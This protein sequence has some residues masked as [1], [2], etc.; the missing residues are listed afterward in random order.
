MPLSSKDPYNDLMKERLPLEN[1]L[2]SFVE[3][4]GDEIDG[5]QIVARLIEPS[6]GAS[7]TIVMLDKFA[8]EMPSACSV[9]ELVSTLSEHGFKG[10]DDYF[11]EQNSSLPHVLTTR[12]GIP[13]TL[14]IV[15]L[16]VARRL[17]MD[18]YGINSPG[19]FLASVEDVVIDPFRMAIIDPS[20]LERWLEKTKLTSEKAFP[21]ANSV[22]VVTRMLNNLKGLALQKA[23]YSRAIDLCS[24]QLVLAEQTLP[25]LMER[26]DLWAKA[27]NPSMA[28]YDLDQALAL[29][30]DDSLRAEILE[31]RKFFG[32][33]DS[34]KLH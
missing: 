24:Y 16:G 9:E 3:A 22:D 10:S 13:I 34:T 19:H 2:E 23:N 31:R 29:V 1:D 32:E 14:A 4:G 33:S 5:A 27:G 17:G 30:K 11:N 8:K 7:K 15:I 21:R 12:R 20:A 25:L 6:V 18:A 28:V 26:V